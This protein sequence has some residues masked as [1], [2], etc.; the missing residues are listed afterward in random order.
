MPVKMSADRLEGVR[1]A[2]DRLLEIVRRT[3]SQAGGG[4]VSAGANGFDILHR[5]PFTAPMPEGPQTQTYLRALLTQRAA[6]DLPYTMEVWHLNK[7]VLNVQ[8]DDNDKIQV[9]SFR[10]GEWE[11]KLA[12]LA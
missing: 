1:R 10:L 2:R 6:R 11:K 9:I 12:A 7:K 8:W 4:W 3:G 5:T